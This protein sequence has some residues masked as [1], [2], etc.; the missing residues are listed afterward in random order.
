MRP[1]REQKQ[2][3]NRKPTTKTGGL[4]PK[5]TRRTQ[6]LTDQKET[7][8]K[9]I[10]ARDSHPPRERARQSTGA[11]EEGGAQG[12]A[13]RGSRS[14]RSAP[15]RRCRGRGR[16]AVRDERRGGGGREQRTVACADPWRGSQCR[17]GARSPPVACG[18]GRGEAAGRPGSASES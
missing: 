5:L 3:K 18:G 9:A 7:E 12:R 2:I 17:R 10:A 16:I 14:S 15:C 13:S 8:S 11:A 4:I 6:I 1:A